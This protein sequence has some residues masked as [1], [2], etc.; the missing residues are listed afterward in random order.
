MR[1]ISVGSFRCRHDRRSGFLQI[2]AGSASRLPNEIVASSSPSLRLRANLLLFHANAAAV[3]N[4]YG[5]FVMLASPRPKHYV[6]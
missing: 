6:S 3:G 4:Q 1:F 2:A 5:A